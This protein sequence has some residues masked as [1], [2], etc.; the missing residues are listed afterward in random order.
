MTHTNSIT[1][2]T[3]AESVIDKEEGIL[4]RQSVRYATMLVI[5]ILVVTTLTFGGRRFTKLSRTPLT[6]HSV[7]WHGMHVNVGPDFALTV[8]DTMLRAT[9][10]LTTSLVSADLLVFKWKASGNSPS[11]EKAKRE[12]A[13]DSRCN[14]ES[15]SVAGLARDCILYKHGSLADSSLTNTSVCVVPTARIESHYRCLNLAC[16]Q[17]RSIEASSFAS[18]RL[19]AR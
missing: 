4:K 2:Q 18:L 17:F 16:Q 6:E 19:P 13:S 9:H 12:C 5:G 1:S 3:R 15:D 10:R 8:A 14:V 11:L 7:D